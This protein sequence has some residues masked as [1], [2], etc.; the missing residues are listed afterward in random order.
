MIKAISKLIDDLA[1]RRH[2]RVFLAGIQRPFSTDR[3]WSGWMP[4][5]DTRA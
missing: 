1:T 2:S 4:D 3:Q 5:D